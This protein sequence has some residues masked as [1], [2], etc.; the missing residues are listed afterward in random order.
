MTESTREPGAPSPEG[1]AEAVP[2]RIDVTTS[3]DSTTSAVPTTPP[4][5]DA[6]AA[7]TAT[8]GTA[9]TA[10]AG[11][12]DPD[13]TLELPPS[14]EPA[15]V[16]ADLPLE[17]PEVGASSETTT[18][19]DAVGGSA[20][21]ADAD[22]A[23]D[24]ALAPPSAT[25]SD[26]ASSGTT[27]AGSTTG[28]PAATGTASAGTPATD[29]VPTDAAAPSTGA[30]TSDAAWSEAA[31]SEVT[32]A[33]TATT[34]AAPAAAESTGATATDGVS[35]ETAPA[36]PAPA[37]TAAA[38]AGAAPAAGAA[39]GE[40]LRTDRIQLAGESGQTISVGVRT[41]LGKHMVRQF[42]EDSNVWDTEQCTLERGADGA[43]Q[44]VPQAGTT[45]ETLVNGEAVTEP[46]PL[47]E[48]DVL[49]VGRAAKGISKLPLTVRVG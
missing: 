41:P 32:P 46:R 36:A 47:R 16:D 19:A 48:G 12:S 10:G 42:G 35:A 29:A 43:W 44:V 5:S 11:V 14:T 15:A 45:N 4:A 30:V 13:A 34:G 17:P 49:A 37:D 38:A 9:G 33:A 27:D 39:S 8:A 20:P 23:G 3:A 2:P 28:G 6:P 21:P 1:T 31:A 18:P 25:V 7:G 24:E 22:T 26:T 40:P